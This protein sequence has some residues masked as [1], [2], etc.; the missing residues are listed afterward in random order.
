MDVLNF[1]AVIQR[2]SWAGQDQNLCLGYPDAHPYLTNPGKLGA[3][4]GRYANRINQ[5]RAVID[6]KSYEF[7][8]NNGAHCLHGGRETLG[9]RAFEVLELSK[10]HVVLFQ[11]LPDGHM[12]FPGD[13][14]VWVTYRLLGATIQ[15]D[16]RAKTNATTLCNITGHSYFNFSGAPTIA[17]HQF[18][19]AAL[20]D[21]C[22]KY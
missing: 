18:Q 14:D 5:A 10:S 3:I 6:G 1:G 2:I 21:L 16:I 17:D 9:L 13:L 11:T 20:F 12:G 15:I 7:D 19:V 8:A 4:V 22:Q